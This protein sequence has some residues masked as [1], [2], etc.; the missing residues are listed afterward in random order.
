MYKGVE[1]RVQAISKATGQGSPASRA[2]F[3]TRGGKQ[4]PGRSDSRRFAGQGW[5]VLTAALQSPLQNRL[6]E[7]VCVPKKAAIP[8][9]SVSR[10]FH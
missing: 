5:S 1:R 2:G 9:K 4:R 6:P 3:D 8:L 10:W 7:P